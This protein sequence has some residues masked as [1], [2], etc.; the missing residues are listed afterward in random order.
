MALRTTLHE[1]LRDGQRKAAATPAA[2][3]LVVCGELLKVRVAV[4]AQVD[5][6]WLKGGK[7]HPKPLTAHQEA[8][9]AE[10]AR[11]LVVRAQLRDVAKVDVRNAAILERKD[12]PGVGVAVE[13]AKLEQLPH[14][15]HDADLDEVLQRR[16]LARE[17]WGRTR[18]VTGQ[19]PA[20][21]HG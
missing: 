7:Q 15:H 11:L 4:Q 2:H 14:A 10:V 20:W 17:R 21:A 6:K 18:K 5:E 1:P 16:E 13:E 9:V 8:S 19:A 3:L 12:V